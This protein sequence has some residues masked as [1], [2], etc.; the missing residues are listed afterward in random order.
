MSRGTDLWVQL[1]EGREVMLPC[2]TPELREEVRA[3]DAPLFRGLRAQL[4]GMSGKVALVLSRAA[5]TSRPAGAEEITADTLT[6]RES[7]ELIA[8]VMAHDAGDGARRAVEADRDV[9]A[10]VGI[11]STLDECPMRSLRKRA[12]KLFPAVTP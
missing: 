8:A 5:W 10:L 7:R 3:L 1:S 11:G 12:A 6:L 4:E 2:P 9:F